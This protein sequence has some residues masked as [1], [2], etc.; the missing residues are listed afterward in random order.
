MRIQ[1]FLDVTEEITRNVQ[2]LHIS[3]I[4]RSAK[5]RIAVLSLLLRSSACGS[6]CGNF[7]CRSLLQLLWKTVHGKEDWSSHSSCFR[8]CWVPLANNSLFP[9]VVMF[10]LYIGSLL[11]WICTC[12][13]NSQYSLL[14]CFG[15]GHPWINFSYDSL[16]P[17]V[18]LTAYLSGWY[19]E[20]RG[21]GPVDLPSLHFVPI[22]MY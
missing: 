1:V 16:V 13:Q 5:L 11:K 20:P 2:E 22:Y 10:F 18:M 8:I 15:R 3:C 7:C 17:L 6:E 4:C 19:F 14:N 21:R 12:R 9:V